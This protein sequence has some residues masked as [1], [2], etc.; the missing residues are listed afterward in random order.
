MFVNGCD[1][2]FAF[3]GLKWY[4]VVHPFIG[5]ERMC[6]L[7]YLTIFR[8]GVCT[9]CPECVRQKMSLIVAKLNLVKLMLSGDAHE[10]YLVHTS[11]VHECS[12]G[13]SFMHTCMH[14]ASCQLG[15][16]SF[17]LRLILFFVFKKLA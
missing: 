3:F 6:S 14:R 2:L 8:R 9:V 15:E 16:P 5:W 17:V 1:Q 4:R 13:S 10:M 7:K 12:E 11:S